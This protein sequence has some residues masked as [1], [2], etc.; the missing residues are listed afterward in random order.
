MCC[1]D[2]TSKRLDAALSMYYTWA[3]NAGT[4]TADLLLVLVLLL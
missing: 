2:T 3:T 1:G 4:A